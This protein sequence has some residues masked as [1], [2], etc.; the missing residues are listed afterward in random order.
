MK[1]LKL[2][3]TDRKWSRIHAAEITRSTRDADHFG[4]LNLSNDI[5]KDTDTET[6]SLI[7]IT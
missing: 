6:E 1:K 4:F 5:Q 3:L 7:E 2:N